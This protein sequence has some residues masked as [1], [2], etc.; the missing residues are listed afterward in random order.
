MEL[1][2]L[3]KV[4]IF[5]TKLDLDL[6]VMEEYCLD[7]RNNNDGRVLSNVGGYQSDPV[8]IPELEKEVNR[9]INVYTK[10]CGLDCKLVVGEVWININGSRDYNEMHRH[11][12]SIFSGVYYVKTPNKS[13]N[14]VFESPGADIMNYHHAGINFNESNLF[15]GTTYWREAKENVL[16]IFPG[17]LKHQVEPNLSNEERISI[18]FNTMQSL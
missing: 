15:N 14:I 13:G 18:S 7:H 11:A 17:W 9:C 10:T 1:I 8:K 12:G 6:G 16:Y 2:E 5:A 4:S 3:F